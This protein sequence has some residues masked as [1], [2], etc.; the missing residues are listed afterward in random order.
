M[1]TTIQISNEVKH[2][3]DKKKIFARE[4]YNEVIEKML[5]DEVELN[6]ETKR[7]I[8]EAIKRYKTGKH[9]THEQA[10]KELGL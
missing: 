6:E 2:E 8:E 1:P 10:K 4:T 5:E 7:E 3:L 9:I